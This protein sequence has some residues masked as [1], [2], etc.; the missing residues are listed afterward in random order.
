MSLRTHN[1][2]VAKLRVLEKCLFMNFRN[3]LHFVVILHYFK[4]HL[5]CF[6]IGPTKD[7]LHH[8]V[9]FMLI[10]VEI[11]LIQKVRLVFKL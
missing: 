6:E 2:I 10:F 11:V 3:M 9:Q 1:D 5:A 4:E 8:N 7:L